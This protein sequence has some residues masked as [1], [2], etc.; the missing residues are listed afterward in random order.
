VIS[1]LKL[2]LAFDA[3]ALWADAA[4]FSAEEWT[5]HFNVHYYQGD[6]SG[7]ALRA[8]KDAHVGLYP[9]P[10]A[11]SFCNTGM[12]DRCK[13][14]PAVLDAFECDLETARFLRLGPGATIREHRDYKLSL[15]D[16]IAR[17]HIPVKT[18]SNVEFFLDHERID[19]QQ[20]E[21]WY[22]NFNL[23]HSVENKGEETRIH[24]VIDCIVNDWLRSFFPET[25]APV[26][27]VG[28]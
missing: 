4:S 18:S 2:P 24:L 19:M 1:T 3:A 10:A 22:L 5:P 16:G 7:I 26:I 9:D 14:V 23:P 17:V 8:A 27:T 13:Y 21:A 15:E 28:S 20:G 25:S 11:T 6:W 12:L